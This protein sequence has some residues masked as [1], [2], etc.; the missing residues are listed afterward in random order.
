MTLLLLLGI[1]FEEI[2][3]TGKSEM[4]QGILASQG[5][6]RVWDVNSA[7][8]DF[9]IRGDSDFDTSLS[10]YLGISAFSFSPFSYE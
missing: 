6:S 7:E 3:V 8:M 4:E 9:C 10:F 1:R 2:D 5:D